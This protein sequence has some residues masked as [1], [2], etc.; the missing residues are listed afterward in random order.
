MLFLWLAASC[1]AADSAPADNVSSGNPSRTVLSRMTW[2][3]EEIA[4]H[5]RL[6]FRDAAPELTDF[7]YDAL[8]AELRSLEKAF[9]TAVLPAANA[10]AIADD[11]SPHFSRHR[12]RVP[13]LSLA[14]TH[15]TDGV[16]A[17]CDAIA[18]LVPAGANA[19][20]PALFTVEPK[21]DGVAVSAVY[22]N[23]KLVRVLTRGDGQQGD[24]VT[25][26]ARRITG[27][28]KALRDSVGE[29]LPR[30]VEIRG[31]V[32]CQFSVFEKQ[33]RALGA[34]G[35][36][37]FASPRNFAA[38]TLKLH[39]PDEVARR[40]LSVVFYGTG[41]VVPDL[42]GVK[43]YAKQL[44]WLREKGLPTVTDTVEA[45][46]AA[47]VMDALRALGKKRSRLPYPVDGAVIKVNPLTLR[48]Q[49]GSAADAP[50]WALAFKFPPDRVKSVLESI[51]LQVGATGTITPVAQLKP[52]RL[53]GVNVQRATLYNP[54]NITRLD[55][56]E[57]DTVFV[58]R[59]GDV[60][61]A[62]TGVDLSLRPATAKV[63]AFPEKC[64]TCGMPILLENNG[65]I[66]RH[67]N[68]ACPLRIIQRI[69]RFVSRPHANIAG[70]GASTTQKLID[71]GLVREI[72]DIYKLSRNSLLSNT[73]MNA[74]SV[75]KLLAAIERSRHAEHWRILAG[76]GIEDVGVSTARK[77]LTHFGSLRAVATADRPALETSGIPPAAARAIQKFFANKVW[78]DFAGQFPPPR[79]PE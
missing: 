44:A 28:P 48:Q 50:R 40:G 38:G 24:D 18:R 1:A 31:E 47:S 35:A 15:T 49:L 11:H 51:T 79:P 32:Y 26:N 41:A 43:T 42:N 74:A 2:L 34:A 29:T 61:P 17:F 65:A 54:A 78:S 12:H 53:G 77:L 9:P 62:V 67:T 59:R 20:T 23:G 52:V 64:S 63:F 76:L 57:G 73:R 70:M 30:F 16:R 37:P 19:T 72:P 75:D 69:K 6:Y 46:D 60:I 66:A 68:P 10:G 39:D 55:L 45:K 3:R 27:I 33:N 36:T 58:E 13:M 5:D 7:E 14:K 56:R 8:C 25:A 21:F 71:A 22:E 4:R